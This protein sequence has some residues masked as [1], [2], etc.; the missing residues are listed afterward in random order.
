M[1]RTYNRTKIIATTGPSCNTYEILLEMVYT[2]VDVFRFNFSHGG[3]DGHKILFDI[4]H[5]INEE[6]H[7]SIGIL[8]D[9]QG[10]K[11]RLGL[12]KDNLIRLET[13]NTVRISNQKQESTEEL[14]YIS[15]PRLPQDAKKG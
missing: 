6:H 5:R 9:L 14:L 8:A 15:Y 11:I 13:G 3:Y 10:P 1:I 12:V 4:V 2:G 7:M